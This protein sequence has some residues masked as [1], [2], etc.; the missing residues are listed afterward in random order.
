MRRL[1]LVIAAATL[2]CSG[3]PP[4]AADPPPKPSAAA[5]S[6]PDTPA[7]GGEVETPAPDPGGS[8]AAAM[9]A[10]GQPAPDFELRD[11]D[12][13][14][15]KLSDYRGKAV[16]LEWFNPEC[17]FVN[18][19]HTEGSLATMAAHEQKSGI[20]WLAIN[21]GGE[22]KQGHGVDKNRAG[23]EKFKMGHPVLL[24]SDGTIGHTYEAKKTPHMYLVD[25][26]GILLY[27]GAIDNAPFGEVDGDGDKVNFVAA[28][29]A[30]VRANR[31]VETAD[32]PPYGC[33][34]K[35]A[36]K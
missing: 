33:S 26:Q 27:R 36:K 16:V 25:P 23:V 14:M 18:H 34:V 15:H 24:D 7:A 17:P 19:A 21:S 4:P 3:Q 30:D 11:L 8:P 2:A 6:Q 13:K 12:G 1:A 20:V 31:P 5:Q 9:A 29:L 32:T 35:Y 28:A 22:G 10:L